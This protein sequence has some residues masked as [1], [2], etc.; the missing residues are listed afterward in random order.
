MD[1]SRVKSITLE[2]IQVAERG[3]FE[4]MTGLD[5][6][7]GDFE[8]PLFAPF[9]PVLSLRKLLR[10]SKKEV[11]AVPWWNPSTNDN[12]EIGRIYC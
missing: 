5:E 9:A 11:A 6:D 10:Q 7:D 12:E 3:H 1:S 8:G 2:E 4:P